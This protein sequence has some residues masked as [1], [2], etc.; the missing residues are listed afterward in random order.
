MMKSPKKRTRGEKYILRLYVSG[1]T[2][3]SA[4]AVKT[5]KRVCELYMKNRY[6]LE[7]I[8][9]YQQPNR[10]RGERIAVVPT[11]IKQCPPPPRR[12]VRG[13]SNQKNVLLGLGLSKREG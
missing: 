5:I 6:E 10:A 8:D 4:R 12:L 2:L 3:K 1:S 13:M 9:V 11:L 7:V